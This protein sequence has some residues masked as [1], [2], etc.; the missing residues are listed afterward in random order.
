SLASPPLVIAYSLAGSM[1]FDFETEA[2][3]QDRDGN[4]VFL[5]DI[6]P[7]PAEGEQIA[8]DSIDS[9]TSNEKYATV[10]DGDEH[11]RAL[12]TPAGNVFEWDERSTY[13]RK[14]PYFE[15]MGLNPEPVTDIEG[16]RVL[17]KLGDSVTTDHISPAGS[18][19]ADTPAGK[20]L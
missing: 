19:K 17:L 13:A 11:W 14:A 20:Y 2:L 15:G 1:D 3:G 12:P 18:F 4:D 5:R 16:A 10:F 8:N 6:W 7:D 9:Q